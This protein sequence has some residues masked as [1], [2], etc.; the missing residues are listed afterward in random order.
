MLHLRQYE[1]DKG[2]DAQIFI[3]DRV[4]RVSSSILSSL[5]PI[6]AQAFGRQTGETYMIKLYED[7]VAFYPLLQVAHGIFVPQTNLSMEILARLADILRRY[8]ISPQSRVYG[9]VQT[10]FTI[11]TVK[12]QV[13]NLLTGD[14]S[15]LLFVAKALGPSELQR[16]L[17]NLF[18]YVGNYDE[19]IR[20]GDQR[21]CLILGRK[22]PLLRVYADNLQRVS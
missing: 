14:L 13:V 12:P 17:L 7:P 19:G 9:L 22:P 18:L 8:S 11:R 4:F 3:E 1:I 21:S 10:C 5:S 15:K 2:G 16:A 20:N 6:F